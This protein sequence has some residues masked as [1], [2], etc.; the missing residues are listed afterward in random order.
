MGALPGA[1]SQPAARPASPA[2]DPAS[3]RRRRGHPRCPGELVP[4]P[5]CVLTGSCSAPCPCP[6]SA[7]LEGTS[8]PRPFLIIFQ[9]QLFFFKL[10]F[11]KQLGLYENALFTSLNSRGSGK[12]ECFVVTLLR[13]DYEGSRVYV[14]FD[15]MFFFFFF[16]LEPHNLA[17]LSYHPSYLMLS[18]V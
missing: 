12:P 11:F 1:E 6:H 17:L 4:R 2:R 14:V 15:V 7:A 3:R 18:Q 16:F 9:I 8:L 5:P 10:F 13:T